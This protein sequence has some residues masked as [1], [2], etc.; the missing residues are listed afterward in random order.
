MRRRKLDVPPFVFCVGVRGW[1]E[2]RDE[3][4]NTVLDD[5]TRVRSTG[6]NLRTILV[7]VKCQGEYVTKP[8]I[9]WDNS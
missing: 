1:E 2:R 5:S 8:L 4:S 7:L 6:L 9:R 3:R